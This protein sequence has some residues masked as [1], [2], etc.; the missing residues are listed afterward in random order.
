MKYYFLDYRPELEEIGTLGELECQ[1][2]VV[3]VTLHK[4]IA[5]LSSRIRSAHLILRGAEATSTVV[6]V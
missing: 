5:Q 6:L 3:P 1:I 4:E 2:A